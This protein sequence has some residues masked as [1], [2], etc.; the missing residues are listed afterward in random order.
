MGHALHVRCHARGGEGETVSAVNTEGLLRLIQSIPSPRAEPFRRGLAQAG[1][2]RI[3]ES[4]NPV[5]A[6]GRALETYRRMGHDDAWIQ[7]RLLAVRT[8]RALADQ[9]VEGGVEGATDRATL[10]DETMRAW[11]GMDQRQYKRQ[12]GLRMENVRDRMSNLELTLQMLAEVAT[13]EIAKQR[14]PKTFAEH[15]DVV[16]CGGAIAAVARETVESCTGK[17]MVIPPKASEQDS[18]LLSSPPQKG[19][20]EHNPP[21]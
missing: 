15:Q 16:R 5:L 1:Y 17:S 11:S 7:Q 9:W 2:E 19:C 14:K 8:R 4:Q 12:K 3:R 18:T 13:A 20:D 21:R 10:A 6:L